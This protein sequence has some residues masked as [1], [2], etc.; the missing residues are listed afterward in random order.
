ML[1][2]TYYLKAEKWHKKNFSFIPKT[3]IRWQVY[4]CRWIILFIHKYF[5]NYKIRIFRLLCKSIGNVFFF[6]W[7]CQ[8]W[9]KMNFI[10]FII[11]R[12]NSSNSSIKNLFFSI[13]LVITIF[14]LYINEWGNVIL[15]LMKI[16]I[17][18]YWSNNF[19][20]FIISICL[21]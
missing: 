15:K 14:L 5:E 8:I 16:G 7:A 2:Q 13:F 1:S 17:N 12:F 4:I 19:V 6:G 11:I 10:Y 18:K 21:N 3:P 20:K 9:P